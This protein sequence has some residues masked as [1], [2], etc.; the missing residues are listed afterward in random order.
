[1]SIGRQKNNLRSPDV[2]CGL[3]RL[4]TTAAFK[5]ISKVT[6]GRSDGRRLRFLEVA[7]RSVGADTTD[8]WRANGLV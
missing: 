5:I 3:L 8:R 1:M 6:I 7:R 4:A 2:L